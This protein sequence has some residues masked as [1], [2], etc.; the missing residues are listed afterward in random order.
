MLFTSE[1]VPPC[2]CKNET[3]SLSAI[4]YNIFSFEKNKTQFKWMQIMILFIW[5]INQNNLRKNSDYKFIFSP[6]IPN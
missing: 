1:P 3:N 4:A 6:D 5:Y 2:K